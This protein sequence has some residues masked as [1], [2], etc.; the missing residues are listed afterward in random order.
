MFNFLFKKPAEIVPEEAKKEISLVPNSGG[1]RPGFG[2]VPAQRE[3]DPLASGTDV[4][5]TF[6]FPLE[7]VV[8]VDQKTEDNET[9]FHGAACYRLKDL[10]CHVL[11]SRDFDSRLI[12]VRNT[13]IAAYERIES[14][15]DSQRFGRLFGFHDD[16][17]EG[18]GRFLLGAAYAIGRDGWAEISHTIPYNP[19]STQLAEGWC[20][21][22]AVL[23]REHDRVSLKMSATA[24][25]FN[26]AM[27]VLNE[28]AQSYQ[29]LVQM[30]AKL[31]EKMT[32][33]A[34]KIGK[35]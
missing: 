7:Y 5:R 22:Y 13:R 18:A 20:D 34:K 24:G 4:A 1:V 6:T 16:D 29:Q 26:K 14:A 27:E 28:A 11:L 2:I 25:L 30:D 9:D 21:A 33:I 10:G 15:D 19:K 32:A 8:R 35:L 17:F 31:N 3:G 23:L 12:I